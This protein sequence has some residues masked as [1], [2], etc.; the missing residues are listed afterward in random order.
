MSGSARAIRARNISPYKSCPS[1][2]TV[3]LLTKPLERLVQT[4]SLCMENRKFTMTAYLLYSAVAAVILHRGSASAT[5]VNTTMA[6]DFST[7]FIY[8]YS[9]VE[10]LLTLN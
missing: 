8:Q 9:V 10:D 2:P 1:L 6:Y 4:R 7:V 5:S 3:K